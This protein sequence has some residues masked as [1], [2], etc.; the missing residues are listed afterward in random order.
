MQQFFPESSLAIVS[1][2]DTIS[3]FSATCQA[4]TSP[5]KYIAS[6]S[7][8]RCDNVNWLICVTVITVTA[9]SRSSAHHRDVMACH[10]PS[11][12]IIINQSRTLATLQPLVKPA[13]LKSCEL[14][15]RDCDLSLAL[16]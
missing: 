15:T 7:T 1:A 16:A 4:A 2:R 12:A 6:Y 13:H 5:R 11:F 14:S 10:S 3:V 9:R 8:D